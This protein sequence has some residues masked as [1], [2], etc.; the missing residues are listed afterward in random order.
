M[1]SITVADRSEIVE[2]EN[3]FL[4]LLRKG[5]GRD[6]DSNQ[7]AGNRRQSSLFMFD[8]LAIRDRRFYHAVLCGNSRD[9]AQRGSSE[10]PSAEL[11]SE[12][13]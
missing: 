5:T 13:N 11:A 6:D 7:Q 4:W 10:P 1:G 2:I 8:F 9:P 3:S 12:M